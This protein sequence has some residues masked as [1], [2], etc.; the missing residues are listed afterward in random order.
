MEVDFMPGSLSGLMDRIANLSGDKY[1]QLKVN[2]FCT[3]AQPLQRAAELKA[4]F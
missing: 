1:Q 4:T 2:M 3:H